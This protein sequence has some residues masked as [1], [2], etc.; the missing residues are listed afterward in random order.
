MVNE[1]DVEWT[2]HEGEETAF[3]RKKLAAAS[4]GEDLGCSL[5][6]LD[7]GDRPWPLHYHTGNEEAFYVLA[8][9]GTL[10]R[11]EEREDVALEPGEYVACPAD[12]SGAHQIVNDGD[13]PLR[14]LAISTM[15]E[16][17]VLIYPEVNG[18]GVMA[19]SPPGGDGERPVSG[20]YQRGD[21]VEYW[22]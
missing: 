15:H 13:E 18:L 7:P 8:G 11:G 10:R 1:A 16:P 20:F 6:E 2:D 12:A 3:R 4:D 21:A 14:Y 22:D 19:G 17:D 5:Y 9:E